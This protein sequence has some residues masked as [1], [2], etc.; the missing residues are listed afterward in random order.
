MILQIIV[1]IIIL[2]LLF[3]IFNPVDPKR[4]GPADLIGNPSQ[5]FN[6]SF[7]KSSYLVDN[8]YNYTKPGCIVPCIPGLPCPPCMYVKP[9]FTTECGQTCRETYGPG[10]KPTGTF[11]GH[12]RTGS[13]Q[14]RQFCARDF[15]V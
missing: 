1:I 8:M 4:Y 15:S 14:T 13:G 11:D 6:N 9:P 7:Y 12:C 10:W 3:I 5:I 2:A